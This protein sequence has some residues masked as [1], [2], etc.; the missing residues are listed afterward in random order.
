VINTRKVLV[1][2]KNQPQT[3]NTEIAEMED[4][5]QIQSSVFSE[6]SLR[7]IQNFDDAIRLAQ[8]QFGNIASVS[9]EIGD[10]FVVL[11]TDEKAILVGIPCLALE[12]EF[13][14]GNHGDKGFVSIR[15]VARMPGGVMGKYIINDGST[16]VMRQLKDYTDRTGRRGALMLPGGLR[17]SEYQKTLDNGEVTDATT[18]YL[19][20]AAH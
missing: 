16:G 13:W 19:D 8:A 10:G 20:V 2:S 7:E 17:A 12:W 18:Y 6:D 3:E 11:S 1:M 5:T 15:L 4:T 9:E 14:P